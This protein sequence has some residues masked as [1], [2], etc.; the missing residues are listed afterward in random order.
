MNK[1]HV[2]LTGEIGIGKSTVIKKFLDQ[3][4]LKPTGF[5]TIGTPFRSDGSSE[6]YIMPAQNISFSP[7]FIVAT[8]NKNGQ[9]QTF[10]EIFDKEGSAILRESKEGEMILMDELG[11]MEKDAHL[12]QQAVLDALNGSTPVLGVIKP[13]RTIFLDAVRNHPNVHIL[14]ITKKN[15][16]T[17]WKSLL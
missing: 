1:M 5:L 13:M 6:I 17:I 9:F 15:R 10:P 3:K 12:F 7:Q 14:E 8:R 11:Y 2:F 4:K 16:N